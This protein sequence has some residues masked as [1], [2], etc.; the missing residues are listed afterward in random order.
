LGILETK[1]EISKVLELE[2]IE[3]ED[4]ELEHTEAK[5][6][7]EVEEVTKLE[8]KK[9]KISTPKTIEKR[10]GTKQKTGKEVRT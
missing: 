8:N 5:K 1:Q 7:R 4:E 9:S 6:V 3:L 10:Q 2:N